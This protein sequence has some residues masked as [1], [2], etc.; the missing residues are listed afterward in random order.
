M[1][2]EARPYTYKWHDTLR[3][4]GKQRGPI[5]QFDGVLLEYTNPL[6]GVRRQPLYPA[7]D[8]K[9]RRARQPNR[10]GIRVLPFITEFK[11]KE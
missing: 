9:H 2:N 7:A 10:T 5:D 8:S 11:E 6:T 3:G 4:F 1:T